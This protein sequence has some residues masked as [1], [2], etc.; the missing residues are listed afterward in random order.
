MCICTWVRACGCSGIVFQWY[1]V[2]SFRRYSGMYLLYAHCT[3]RQRFF[4]HMRLRYF[5]H[6]HSTT[7]SV[8]FWYLTRQVGCVTYHSFPRRRRRR[9]LIRFTLDKYKHFTS[10][11]HY[12]F[13]PPRDT[14]T[15]VTSPQSRYSHTPPTPSPCTNFRH[16]TTIQ[17]SA[18][19]LVAELHH[20]GY[21][22]YQW[23]A[24]QGS[25]FAGNMLW[26]CW[27]RLR[28]RTILRRGRWTLLVC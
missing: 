22:R 1:L 21:T 23:C 4:S 8:F 10:Q 5:S 3:S 20:L 13:L 2:A 12:V 6:T 19:C 9:S 17:T 16:S 27:G 7:L 18:C 28:W 11:S 25:E 14:N 26:R 15:T 24:W